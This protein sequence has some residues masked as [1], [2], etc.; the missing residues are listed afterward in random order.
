MAC[1]GIAGAYEQLADGDQAARVAVRSS[2]TAEDT[3]SASFAGMNET[4]LNV[5]RRRRA[6]RESLHRQPAVQGP[7]GRKLST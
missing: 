3:A 2:A 1:R 4:F 6:T 7:L 5:F